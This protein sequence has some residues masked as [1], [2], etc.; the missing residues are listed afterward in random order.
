MVAPREPEPALAAPGVGNLLTP[1]QQ[2]I[3]GPRANRRRR[4]RPFSH[5]HVEIDLESKSPNPAGVP[6]L[7]RLAALL[8]E[9]RIVERGTLVMMA[10]ATLHALSARRFRRIDHWEV[11]PG[12]WLPPPTPGPNRGGIEPVGE[13][14]VTL[15][16]GGWSA[17][18]SARV[19]AARLSDLSGNRIDVTVRRIHRERRHAMSL[20]LWGVWTQATVHDLEGSIRERLPVVNSRMTKYQ[21]A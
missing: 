17:V 5:V 19:F 7:E 6:I 16:G 21:Y 4:D 1:P 8:G 9:K 13:L 15:E 3:G 14:L 11:T 20:D 2:T 10:A 12:G 18:A